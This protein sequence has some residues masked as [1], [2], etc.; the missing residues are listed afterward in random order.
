MKTVRRIG[1]LGHYG[2]RNLGDEAII[3]AVLQNLKTRLPAV[4]LVGF[5]INPED[6]RSR[7]GIEAYPVR[8]RS[9]GP[10][11]P[12]GA[13]TENSSLPADDAC[14]PPQP[15]KT[16]LK[17][18]IKS[19]PVL[20]RVA[21]G[22]V[23]ALS[24]TRKLV[25][26]LGFL[27]RGFGQLK[28]VDALLVTGSNQFLDN[29]GGPWGFP[30]TL[31]K[32]SVLARLTGTRLFFVSIG[33]GPLSQPLSF[34]FIRWA[35]HFSAYVSLRDLPS[36]QM[37][38]DLVGYKG[39]SYVTPDLAHSLSVA[40]V[41]PTALP[42]SRTVTDLPVVGINPM[43]LFDPRYWCEADASR[44]R[45]YV[46]KIADFS[47]K[48]LEN[49][50]P[51]FFFPTQEKD[52]NVISDVLA[53]LQDRG[54]LDAPK[55]DYVLACNSVDD[56]LANIAAC[57]MTV[58]TRFHGT[59]LSLLLEKPLLGI[60]YYQKAK[61]LLSASGQAAFAFDHVAFQADELWNGFEKLTE[62]RHDAKEQIIRKNAEYAA[63]LDQQYRDI[64]DIM[65][66]P[67]R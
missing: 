22:I 49:G 55:E 5:S 29:F 57:D 23:N 33:A 2:N 58:P 12:A 54:A 60:C 38:H 27:C 51:V 13:P 50:Y 52:N 25:Y 32:W 65:E 19:T 64:I 43:P 46:D 6:T 9:P 42:L 59:V 4:D 18:I 40:H 61:E 34:R 21:Y 66:G 26:E 30:Y 16:G 35:L 1:I 17:S 53:I 48:L 14:S 8:Y 11:A 67:S 7:H 15:G 28:S 62:E 47:Q 39:Q 44:Y 10:G 3:Q 63:A 41:K 36:Q 20:N 24:M 45:Q 31:L 56:L 37:L